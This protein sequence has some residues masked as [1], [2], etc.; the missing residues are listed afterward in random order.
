MPLPPH[1]STTG[2]DAR[3]DTRTGIRARSGGP[4]TVRAAAVVSAAPRAEARR[5]G[6]AVRVLPYTL[7][8]AVLSSRAVWLLFAGLACGFAL[9]TEVATH[10][11]WGG[12]A[13][14]GYLSAAVAPG[15]RAPVLAAALA[16]AL[17]LAVLVGTGAAQLEVEVVEA[18][19]TRLLDSGSPYHP[20]P[21]RTA[22]YNPYLP[23]MALFGLPSALTGGG[24]LT[25]PRLWFGLTF[26]IILTLAF[27]RPGPGN[28]GTRTPGGALR[29]AFLL[30]CPPVAMSLAVS[31]IDLPLIGLMCLGTVLAVRR[32]PGTA[33]LVL[34]LA[35][36]MKWTAWPGLA[37]ACAALAA[38][39]GRRTALRCGLVAATTVTALVVPVLI[40]DPASF[41]RHAVAFPL[42]L[43]DTPSPAASPLP[44]RLIADCLPGGSGRS[45]ALALLCAA[46]LLM[47]VSLVARPPTT[48]RAA[49]NRT[50]LGLLLALGLAPA[51]RY[52]YLLYPLVLAFLALSAHRPAPPAPPA[53][54]RH[55]TPCRSRSRPHH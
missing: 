24:P 35:S 52:G 17:P 54:G 30:A 45:V 12:T 50:A 41:F 46:A 49:A 10:R 4:R 5:T 34:G 19:A 25:D 22:D 31:G 48:V 28:A 53:T 11:F 29:P 33:G 8:T 36:A 9:V 3:T 26:A 21:A 13:A 23:A 6:A 38:I 39:H 43:A 20:D 40:G 14:V 51:S 32:R 44:G 55:L 27:R 7:L 1:I 47:A 18:A 16:A 42:G 37:V 2:T 15:R